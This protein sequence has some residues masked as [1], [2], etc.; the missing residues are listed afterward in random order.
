MC[1]TRA[2]AVES[3][4]NA[5]P[6]RKAL[7]R[8]LSWALPAL[9]IAF[10][11]WIVPVRDRCV[12]P[13]APAT[14]RVAV[15]RTETTCIL[16]VKSGDVTIPASECAALQCEPGLASTLAHARV[17]LLGA[18]LALYFAATFIWAVRWRI[19]L[20]LAD[21]RASVL[22]VWRV[23]LESQAMGI[24]LPGSVGGDALRVAKLVRGGGAS[25]GIALASVMVDRAIGL[26]MTAVIAIVAAYGFGGGLPGATGYALLAIPVGFV[27]GI[28]VLRS[29]RFR[30]MRILQEGRIARMAKP[31]LQIVAQP[32]GVR[33]IAAATTV[34]VFNSSVQFFIV[35]ATLYALGAAPTDERWV[36]VGIAMAMIASAIPALPGGWGTGDAAF[37]FFFGFAGV[38]PGIAFGVSLLYRAYW[39][40]LGVVGGIVNV[41]PR[42]K[43]D[44]AKDATPPA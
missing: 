16:H 40:V 35:R 17:P 25:I 24:V 43:S 12:D 3:T 30:A 20:R 15:T 38:P 19:L 34:S 1:N 8:I 7:T 44:E 39:Y 27:V 10:V 28:A 32:N 5:R 42:R 31:V 36:F 6:E 33:A 21:V 2:V 13:R 4:P 22:D 14:T 41:L 11:V 9:A 18:I 29:P 37:V 23:L 26:M